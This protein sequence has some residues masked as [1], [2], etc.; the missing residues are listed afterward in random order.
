MHDSS[1]NDTLNYTYRF[2]FQNMKEKVFEIELNKETLSFIRPPNSVIPAWAKQTN[3]NCPV[4]DCV[5][6]NKEYCPVAANLNSVIEFFDGIPSYEKV[7]IYAESN[8]RT[9]FK[10]TS[11]QTGAGSLIG[12]IMVTSGCPVLDKLKPLVQ[13]HLPFATIEETEFRAFSMYLI[14]QFLRNK[15]G[16][17]PDWELKGLKYIYEEIQKINRNI[18]QKIADMEKMDTSI[19]AVVILDNF[20]SYVSLDLD[21]EELSNL[22]TLFKCWLE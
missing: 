14:A 16:L 4:K 22:E 11:I 17:N 7:K 5:E 8:Q 19:N 21:E 20:A 2:I 3:I 1:E 12:I 18:A 10:E 15:K 6:I 9:Y 13:Y